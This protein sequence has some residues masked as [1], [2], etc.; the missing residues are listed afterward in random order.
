M[1][2]DYFDFSLLILLIKYSSFDQPWITTKVKYTF[3][4]P[5]FVYLILLITTNITAWIRLLCTLLIDNDGVD[6][7]PFVNLVLA[8]ISIMLLSF[9]HVI[10]VASYIICF[11]H[12]KMHNTYIVYPYIRNLYPITL[13]LQLHWQY[14][15]RQHSIIQ[16]LEPLLPWIVYIVCKISIIWQLVKYDNINA[17]IPWGVTVMVFELT[18]VPRQHSIIQQLEPLLPWIV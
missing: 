8:L 2:C 9:N 16:Q 7:S 3:S 18:I 15:P 10:E 6:T 14:L 5:R 13:C 1:S 11:L 17:Y 12:I 4:D